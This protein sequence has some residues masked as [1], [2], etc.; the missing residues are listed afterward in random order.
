MDQSTSH[1]SRHP[2]CILLLAVKESRGVHLAKAESVGLL[3]I[4]LDAGLG[5]PRPACPVLGRNRTRLGIRCRHRAACHRHHPSW[6]IHRCRGQTRFITSGTHVHLPQHDS[7]G[8]DGNN[9]LQRHGFLRYPLLPAAVFPGRAWRIAHQL[10]CRHAP[11]D[12]RASVLFFPVSIA[13]GATLTPDLDL[14]F[15]RLATTSGT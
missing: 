1:R 4:Y 9:L 3:W 7:S 15:P 11:F 12:I 5:Y 10:W 2:R 8:I 6:R 14:S 13:R